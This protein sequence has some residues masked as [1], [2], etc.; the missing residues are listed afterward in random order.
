MNRYDVDVMHIKVEINPEVI[1]L[2]P[3]S[4]TLSVILWRHPSV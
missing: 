4:K 3:S 2:Q 1:S